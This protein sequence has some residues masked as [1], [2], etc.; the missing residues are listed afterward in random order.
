MRNCIPSSSRLL[1]ASI[2]LAVSCL[3]CTSNAW[4]WNGHGHRLVV[5]LAEPELTTQTK[6]G[7]HALLAL[8][9]DA[10]LESVS[11]WA[12]EHR[13]PTTSTWHYINFPR[14]ECSY[15]PERD[16]PDGQCV[17]GALEQQ[18]T[19]LASDAPPEKRLLALKYITHFAADIHQPL[20]A[21]FGDDRGGNSY[22]VQALDNGTNLHALWDS[23][24]GLLAPDNLAGIENRLAPRMQSEP[25][26]DLAV[27]AI[28]EESCRIAS[29]KTFY[30]ER[31][32]PAI[33]V[34]QHRS[35]VDQQML[36]AAK[37]LAGM[38]N[39]AFAH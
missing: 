18:L 6:A 35:V 9:P 27:A 20:H 8:E 32:V 2:T 31:K 23:G 39:K 3:L 24:V 10:T 37:R 11:T 26:S 5:R 30:P 29:A 38:L 34:E 16:C 21:A 36:K 13:D 22:Q 28:A 15:V 19:M 17:V 25:N 4:G 12:D 33:Y 14:G 7:I 1:V